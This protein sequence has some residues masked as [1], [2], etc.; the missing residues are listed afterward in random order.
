M[1]DSDIT[2]GERIIGHISGTYDGRTITVE[3]TAARH[4]IMQQLV[5]S[6]LP[7]LYGF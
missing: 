1:A 6:S 5:M 2:P 7:A 4:I 3:V